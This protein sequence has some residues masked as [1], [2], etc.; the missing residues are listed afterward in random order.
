MNKQQGTSNI[1]HNP[2]KPLQGNNPKAPTAASA[3]TIHP[4]ILKN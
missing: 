3:K 2:T 1:T 4:T